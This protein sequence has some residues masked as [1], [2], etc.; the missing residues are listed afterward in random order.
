MTAD[1][2]SK[3]P[4]ATS[5][6]A[7]L[8]SAG[9]RRL[10]RGA[11][12]GA[13]VLL[14]VHAKTALGTGTCRSPSS[15]LSG[16]TSPRP[17]DGSTCS[18]GRH[19]G[20]WKLPASCSSWPSGCTR[21]DF[22][23]KTLHTGT[24]CPNNYRDLRL[25][26]IDAGKRGISMSSLGLNGTSRSAWEAMCFSDGTPGNELQK[27]I[28]AALFNAKAFTSAAARYPLSPAQ[29]I[30]MWDAVKLGGSYCPGAIIGG[31][32]SLAWTQAQVIT[33][34]KSLHGSL[35]EQKIFIRP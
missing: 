16:N 23:G 17:R 11:A 22:S 4:T 8:Q 32:G 15:V 12:G 21:P 30:A 35:T 5:P 29:V 1:P 26:D 34:L 28:C 7:D 31:C 25:S 2:R 33:Y 14:S 19:P 18:G 3:E 9:R 27:H 24:S 20:D 13:G 10:F 6:G